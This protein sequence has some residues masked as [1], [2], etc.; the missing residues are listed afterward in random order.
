VQP[1]AAHRLGQSGVLVL[2]V[3]DE[4]L[5]PGVE[6]AQQFELGQVRLARPAAGEDDG[7]VVGQPPAVPEH[8]TARTGVAAVEDAR[9]VGQLGRREGEG[10]GE[11][12]GVERAAQAQQV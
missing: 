7:V 8:E 1:H 4:R 11:R 5:D 6:R 12:V 3:D 2:G 9:G 10:G